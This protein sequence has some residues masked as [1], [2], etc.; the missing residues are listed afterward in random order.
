M[1]TF[2][3]GEG[4]TSDDLNVKSAAIN[5]ALFAEKFG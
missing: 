2:T 5:K 1:N 3:E 4:L